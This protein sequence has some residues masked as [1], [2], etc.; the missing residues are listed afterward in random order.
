V[1]LVRILA[2]T[3]RLTVFERVGN[4]R[5]TGAD[6]VLG[7]Y[8]KLVLDVR[9]QVFHGVVGRLHLS[10]EIQRLQAGNSDNNFGNFSNATDSRML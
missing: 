4:G 6:A 3:A 2:S 10:A 9:F 5:L 7:R 8:T 1:F